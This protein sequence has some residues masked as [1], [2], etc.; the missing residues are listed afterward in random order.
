MYVPRLGSSISVTLLQIRLVE[1]VF[2]KLSPCGACLSS[3]K[4]H[5]AEAWVVEM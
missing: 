4:V 1:G 5:P 2:S 3:N